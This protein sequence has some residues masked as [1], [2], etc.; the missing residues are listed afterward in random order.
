M[1]NVPSGPAWETTRTHLDRGWSVNDLE[2]VSHVSGPVISR[3]AKAGRQGEEVLIMERSADLLK[4]VTHEALMASKTLQVPT[5]VATWMVTA[6]DAIAWPRQAVADLLGH[7][8]HSLGDIAVGRSKVIS[9][10]T[11]EDVR[12][13]FE[14]CRHRIGTTSWSRVLRRNARLDL[15]M[16]H[17]YADNGRL[18]E[19]LF[20]ERYSGEDEQ[21]LLVREHEALFRLNVVDLH[22]RGATFQ[23]MCTMLGCTHEQILAVLKEAKI[24]AN[25]G[26]ATIVRGVTPPPGR[27][28]TMMRVMQILQE[29][30]NHPEQPAYDFARKLGMMGEDKSGRAAA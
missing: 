25:A 5:W 4:A 6:L 9:R 13:V 26:K 30:R 21:H 29:W 27:L 18:W 28:Y 17:E 1:T 15:R 14:R 8:A 24:P 7:S 2:L 10:E 23:D 16:P 11:A 20:A 3:L 22:R 19:D 12:T